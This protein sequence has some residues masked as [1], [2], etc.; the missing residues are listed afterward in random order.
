MACSN[1]ADVDKKEQRVKRRGRES[2]FQ[3]N[4]GARQVSDIRP[5]GRM[6]R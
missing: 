5:Y 1:R 4:C 3:E 6:R 2:D